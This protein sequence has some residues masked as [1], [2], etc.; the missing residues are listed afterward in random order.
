MEKDI[1]GQKFGWLL[2]LHRISPIGIR[3]IKWLFLCDCGNDVSIYKQHVTTGVTKSCVD[4]GHIRQALAI[5]KH[6]MSRTRE[7]MKYS[8]AKDRCSNTNNTRYKDYGGRG[9]KFLFNSFDEFYA[10]LGAC[11]VELTLDRTNNNGNYEPGNVRWA[12]WE[13]QF[14]TRRPWN[15]KQ[16]LA[17]AV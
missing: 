7:Y 12:T 5:T 4:C 1:T 9:I 13:Q 10:E 15:W 16:K 8:V 14:S 11:P 3:H 17:A 2:A 6:G